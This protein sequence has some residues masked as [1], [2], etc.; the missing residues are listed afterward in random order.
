MDAET[1]RA[2]AK[3][4]RSRAHAACAAKGDGMARLGA[5]RAMEQLAKDLE[6]S[7]PHCGTDRTRKTR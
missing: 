6:A 4:C 3:L 2:V 5:E 1:L 7:A